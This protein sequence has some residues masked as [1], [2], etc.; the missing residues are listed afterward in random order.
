M[1]TKVFDELGFPS[2]FGQTMYQN[3]HLDVLNAE[4]YSSGI[5]Y[6][7]IFNWEFNGS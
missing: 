3:D 2:I 4:K 6:L 1:N 7:L 5:Q